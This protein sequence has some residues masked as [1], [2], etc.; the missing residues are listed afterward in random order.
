MDEQMVKQ[1][2]GFLFALLSVV[3][4]V[5]VTLTVEPL[6]V[7]TC[8]CFLD[9]I[10]ILKDWKI[11]S[12]CLVEWH[13]QSFMF[14]KRTAEEELH[15]CH[16]WQQMQKWKTGG[17]GSTF[18]ILGFCHVITSFQAFPVIFNLISGSV[19]SGTLQRFKLLSS[20]FWTCLNS[21]D[22]LAFWPSSHSVILSC[23]KVS[24]MKF[25]SD[26]D[27]SGFSTVFTSYPF[28]TI[29]CKSGKASCGHWAHT[30]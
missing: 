13:T 28:A 18:P 6:V 12:R 8:A 25:V 3:M 20:S 7:F 22:F 26:T 5:L 2:G 4:A 17:V 11:Q 29:Q 27:N 15:I 14:P 19:N 1:A 24:S 23:V 9:S 30:G 16:C 21:T 10:K